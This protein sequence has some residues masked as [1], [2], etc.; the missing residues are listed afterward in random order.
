MFEQWAEKW[1][2][3]R[4]IGCFVYTKLSKLA[5]AIFPTLNK[6]QESYKDAALSI[7]VIR[8]KHKIFSLAYDEF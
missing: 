8:E 5:N 2:I 1:K 3:H 7:L 6:K 4:S